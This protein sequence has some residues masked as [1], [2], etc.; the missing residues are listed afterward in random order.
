[1]RSV[2]NTCFSPLCSS[3]KIPVFPAIAGRLLNRAANH[4]NGAADFAGFYRSVGHHGRGDGPVFAKI[5]DL[6]RL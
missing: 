3:H 5:K 2:S 6:S 4:V 1:M